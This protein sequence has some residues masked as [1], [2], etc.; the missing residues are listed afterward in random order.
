MQPLKRKHYLTLAVTL[1]LLAAAGGF[2][3]VYCQMNSPLLSAKDTHYLYIDDDDTADSVFDKLSAVSTKEGMKGMRRLANHYDYALSIRTGRYA[4]S[5]QTSVLNVFRQLRNGQQE[6]LMLTVPAVRTMDR[7]A[8]RL[9]AM[10]A[11]P[12]CRPEMKS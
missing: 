7:M 9:S 11:M 3:S 1:L 2:Y 12:T 8:A 6:P 10:L 5:P 4:I